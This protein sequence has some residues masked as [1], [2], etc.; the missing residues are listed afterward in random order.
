MVE[1]LNCLGHDAVVCRNHEDRDVGDLSTTGTHSGERLVSR[2][3]NEGDGTFIALMLSPDLVSTDGLGDS[4]G[5]ARSDIGP[6]NRI[7]KAGLTVVDV[8]H[9]RDNRRTNDEVVLVLLGIKV[10]VERVENFLVLVLGAHN[11]DLVTEFCTK[12]LERSGVE[13]L[14]RRG[15]LAELEQNRDEV[16]GGN[17]EARH[18][19]NFVGEVI[20]RRPLT[21]TNYGRAVTTRDLD[22]AEA[23]GLAHFKLLA[24]RALR[25]ARLG[26]AATA[27]ERTSGVSTATATTGAAAWATRATTG[28]TRCCTGT[29]RTETALATGRT[30]RATR[31]LLERRIG[32][33]TGTSHWAARCVR[34][35]T[36]SA[37]SRHERVVTGRANRT[38]HRR[39]GHKGVVTTGTRHRRSGLR[40]AVE[41]GRG[42]CGNRWLP[43]RLRGFVSRRNIGQIHLCGRARA[44]CGLF[45]RRRCDVLLGQAISGERLT[46]LAGDGRFDR[47]R[48][49]LD[50]LAERTQLLDDL[51]AF[52]AEFSGNLVHAWFS[53]HNSPVR[54]V[55]RTGYATT[56]L[57]NSFRAAH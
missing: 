39:R 54:G 12:N 57:R 26:L 52:D 49:R 47:R 41:T 40:F 13:R 10:D 19:L 38:R 20:D 4:T 46:K 6:T 1:R 51:L 48:R 5:F 3:V 11:L 18:R 24:L 31:A 27:T 55:T 50:E 53:S 21:K 33:T 15:H 44:G 29:R 37:L 34:T 43:A 45:G 35:G 25:L 8:S 42:R 9:D 17:R 2:G 16:T 30:T 23:R 14:G 36:R 56:A 7:E 28:A 32:T 22:A